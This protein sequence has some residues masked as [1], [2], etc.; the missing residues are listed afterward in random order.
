MKRLLVALV[1]L[2]LFA[3]PSFANKPKKEAV[4]KEAKKAADKAAV[5]AEAKKEAVEKKAEEVKK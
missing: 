5:K 4:K 1:A 3:A 2:G